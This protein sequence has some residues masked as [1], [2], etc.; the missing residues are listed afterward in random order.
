MNRP[1]HLCLAS[2]HRAA[3]IALEEL[4]HG[5]SHGARLWARYA[6]ADYQ[7]WKTAQA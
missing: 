4:R 3:R 6:R 2:F 7:A 1:A 5:N